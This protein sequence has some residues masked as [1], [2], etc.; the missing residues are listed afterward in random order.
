MDAT[1]TA[2]VEGRRR[3]DAG[4][5]EWLE[6]LHEFDWGGWWATDGHLNCVAWLVHRC[7][8]ARSTAKDKLRVAHELRRRPLLA[9]ALAAGKI[10][11]CKVRSLTRITGADTD[12]D[13]ALLRAARTHTVAELE[14]SS[15][16]TTTSSTN[17]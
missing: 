5:L 10:S 2:L 7:G 3:L 4:E 9:D 11:Y 17:R 14:G 6:A 12:T 13:A 16:A 15:S 8:M 1:A